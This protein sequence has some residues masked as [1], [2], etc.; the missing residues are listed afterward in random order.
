MRALILMMVCLVSS[1]GALTLEE[2]RNLIHYGVEGLIQSVDEAALVGMEVYSFDEGATLY[3]RN[4]KS[5][6]V[7]AS[8]LKLFTAGAVL[9][10]L[11]GNDCFETRVAVDGE[12]KKGTL[13]GNCYLVGSGDPSLTGIDLVDLVE[14]MGDLQKIEGD[15][16]LDVTCFEDGPMGPGWM[17]DEGSDA[18]AA[19]MSALNIE[20]N[21]LEEQAV[22]HPEEL[23]AAL[24]KG[25]LDRKGIKVTGKVKLGKVIEGATVVARHLSQPMKEL[26]KVAVKDTDN[27]YANCLFK[28]LGPSWEKGKERMEEF[29]LQTIGKNSIV[30]VDGSGLSRYN[31]V[32]P[33]E[34]VEFL[35]KMKSNSLFIDSLAIGGVDGTLKYRMGMIPKKVRGKTGSMTGVSSF[36]GYVT[37]N[38][39]K[40]FALA[41]FV[42]GYVKEGREIK[43]KLEDG[44]CQ[45]LVNLQD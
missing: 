27:L 9:E 22:S 10:Y 12:M 28:K 39:G 14:Q 41:I 6:F 18:W 30:M 11:G 40:E 44:I 8:S 32:A 42:S 7:P 35:K 21:C 43:K 5:R 3:E 26:I 23:T 24:F 1:L 31:A 4:A 37:T 25:I 20:H 16:V 15:V 34:M 19:P 38:T 36:C 45:L 2:K 29:L 17:W 33:H 13:M